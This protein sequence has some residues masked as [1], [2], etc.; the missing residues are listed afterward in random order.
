[1]TGDRANTDPPVNADRYK[2]NDIDPDGDGSVTNSDYA[3]DAGDADT[4]DGNQ[5]ADL[6]VG[7]GV[8]AQWEATATQSS[9]V[10]S[11]STATLSFTLGYSKVLSDGVLVNASDTGFVELAE[12][13]VYDP[14]GVNVSSSTG[15][16]AALP[17]DGFTHP[18]DAN[19]VDT[20]DVVLYCDDPNGSRTVDSVSVAPRFG[21][22]R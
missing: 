6:G 19:V 13:H 17:L 12:V 3:T 11:E 20:V 5:P 16:S 2:G 18:M 14:D 22:K 4:V 10:P 8:P 15:Y 9:S 21:A 7:P 1:M